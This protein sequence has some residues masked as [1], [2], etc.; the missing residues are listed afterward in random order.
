MRRTRSITLSSAASGSTV[1]RGIAE[2]LR[3]ARRIRQ[4]HNGYGRS[5]RTWDGRWKI[6][7]GAAA[8]AGSDGARR[9]LAVCPPDTTPGR[10]PR[11]DRDPVVHDD[12]RAATRR[13]DVGVRA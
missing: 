1:L 5:P 4:S 9:P 2:I 11:V 6:A 8:P 3:A 13:G 10:D 7:L 12:L